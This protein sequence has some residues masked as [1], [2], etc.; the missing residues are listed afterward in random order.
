M[1][2]PLLVRST[3]S[4]RDTRRPLKYADELL[5]VMR[6]Y[7]EKPRTTVGWKGLINDP[8]IDRQTVGQELGG[9]CVEHLAGDGHALVGQVDEELA[10]HAY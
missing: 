1:G 8:D 4:W 2:M 5:I 9:D 6:S 10:R 3:K 7:L